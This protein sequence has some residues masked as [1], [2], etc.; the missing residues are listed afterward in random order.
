MNSSVHSRSSL[1]KK[2]IQ[3]L[4]K[5]PSCT[6]VWRS[7]NFYKLRFFVVTT[8][9]F[10]LFIENFSF[11]ERF[12]TPLLSVQI[13]SCTPSDQNLSNHWV[14]I[15][16][17]RNSDFLLRDKRTIGSTEWTMVRKKQTILVGP[18]QRFV[19]LRTCA[20]FHI[21]ITRHYGAP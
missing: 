3:N 9:S 8:L 18:V 1:F 13:L 16:W 6:L 7:K 2:T 14:S 15:W 21:N 4:I 12:F 19:R 5:I 20:I 11:Y 10:R 17:P